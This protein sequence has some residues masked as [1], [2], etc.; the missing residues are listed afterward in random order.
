MANCNRGG[1]TYKRHAFKRGKCKH[2]G[3]DQLVAVKAG[4]DARHNR[5]ETRRINRKA[6]VSATGGESGSARDRRRQRR[7]NSREFDRAT[8]SVNLNNG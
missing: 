8:V 6:R 7:V 5:R 4:A 1:H 3:A 2:C